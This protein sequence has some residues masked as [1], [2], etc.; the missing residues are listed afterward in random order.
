MASKDLSDRVPGL[1]ISSMSAGNTVADDPGL[2]MT[3]PGTPSVLP[4]PDAMDRL[5]MPEPRTHARTTLVGESGAKGDTAPDEIDRPGG[6]RLAGGYEAAQAPW[7][8]C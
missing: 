3:A 8:E 1:S 7:T 6:W 4:V 5:P 2:S